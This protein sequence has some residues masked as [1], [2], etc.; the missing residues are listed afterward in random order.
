MSTSNQKPT[1]TTFPAFVGGLAAGVI[2]GSLAGAFLPDRAI[3]AGA[4]GLHIGPAPRATPSTPHA[5]AQPDAMPPASTS[6]R[7]QAVVDEK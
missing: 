4:S 5:Q 6:A 7:G 1:S 3:G 2:V